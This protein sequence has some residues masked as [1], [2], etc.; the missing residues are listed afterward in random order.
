MRRINILK[1][2]L[3]PR[4]ARLPVLAEC[5]GT[6]LKRLKRFFIKG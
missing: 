4:Y 3:E 2:I 5:F 6:L 1:M